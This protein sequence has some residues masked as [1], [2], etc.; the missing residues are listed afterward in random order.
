MIIDFHVHIFP[1]ELAPRAIPK[2]AQ[3][4]GIPAF[5]E[6]THKQLLR[7]LDWAGIEKAVIQPV[8]TRPE[9]TEGI[10]SWL[11][12]IRS[13]R[14]DAFAAIFP[15]APSWERD[16][17]R[18]VEQGFRGVKLH[19]DYQE[20]FVDES[21]LFP[22]YKRVFENDLYILFHAGVDI[23][24]P[25]PVH[26][27]P[28]RLRKVVDQFGGERIIA[29]HLGGWQMWEQVETYLLGESLFLDTS[30]SIPYLGKE[31]ARELILAH[32]P[33]KILFATDSPWAPQLSAVGQLQELRLAP[34]I[35][36][37]ILGEN[38]RRILEG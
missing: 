37:V 20:F 16:L 2:L 13:E 28:Q 32:G 18:I 19:P 27:T 11:A 31:R 17:D 21:E 34:E 14:I 1:D 9:Q 10:N 6:G 15:G 24:L 7:S 25:P 30:F 35:L 23:G 8:A 3:G 33:E 4:A 38:A 26:C 29:A 36:D 22:F 5:L 12:Q